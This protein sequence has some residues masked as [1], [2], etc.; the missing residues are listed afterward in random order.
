MDCY[1]PVWSGWWC[2]RCCGYKEHLLYRNIPKW[3]IWFWCVLKWL[4]CSVKIGLC[5]LTVVSYTKCIYVFYLPKDLMSGWKFYLYFPNFI[6]CSFCLSFR[7]YFLFRFLFHVITGFE[8]KLYSI[9]SPLIQ[10]KTQYFYSF[11]VWLSSIFSSA[12]SI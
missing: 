1:W 3:K 10:V 2:K 8:L 9:F 7:F 6:S 4:L 12:S 11:T 5:M